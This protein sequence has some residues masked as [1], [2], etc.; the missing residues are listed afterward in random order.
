VAEESPELYFEIQAL[1]D[2][3]AESLQALSQSVERLRAAVLT[4]DF[5]TFRRL[6]TEGLEYLQG[7]REVTARR[8]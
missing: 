3:G 2:Y 4:R 5:P 8:A 1:N 7:R 6:M